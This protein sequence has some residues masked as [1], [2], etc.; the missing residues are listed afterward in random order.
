MRPPP[1]NTSFIPYSTGLV[2]NAAT[3]SDVVG[4]I[5]EI[6]AER[7]YEGNPCNC[8]SRKRTKI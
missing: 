1:I 3:A 6:V 5:P 4:A 2:K 8:L 7:I